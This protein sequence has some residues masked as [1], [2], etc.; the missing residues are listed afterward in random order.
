MAFKRKL[1]RRPAKRPSPVD[2]ICVIN[3][4]SPQQW[5]AGHVAHLA[6]YTLDLLR[7]RPLH[8]IFDM[9]ALIFSIVVGLFCVDAHARNIA[10]LLGGSGD[11]K[12]QPYTLFDHSVVMSIDYFQKKQYELTTLHDGDRQR[13]NEDVSR[14]LK[15]M[16]LKSLTQNNIETAISQIEDMQLGPNDQVVVVIQTHGN[17]QKADEKTHCV[18]IESPQCWSVDRLKTLQKK[19]GGKAKLAIIDMSC[20]SGATLAL[21]D[22]NTCVITASNKHEMALAADVSDFWMNIREHLKHTD[23]DMSLQTLFDTH[24]VRR[25]RYQYGQKMETELTI[26]GFQI[27]TQTNRLLNAF[28]DSSQGLTSLSFDP[29]RIKDPINDLCRSLDTLSKMKDLI[30]L[31]IRALHANALTDF[32]YLDQTVKELNPKIQRL[33]DLINMPIKFQ[34]KDTGMTT[35]DLAELRK[36]GGW[37]KVADTLTKA[38]QEAYSKKLEAPEKLAALSE[39][40]RYLTSVPD[41]DWPPETNPYSDREVQRLTKEIK[42]SPLKTATEKAMRSRNLLLEAGY[43]KARETQSETSA[44]SRFVL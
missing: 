33:N 39:F 23:S 43:K 34:G 6:P 25:H 21:A 20:F 3:A 2:V 13:S 41:S 42:G 18:S 19:L 5:L 4:V 17:P 9:Y 36:M 35:G 16:P 26:S 28:E 11:P 44:C 38:I 10:L 14:A 32:R 7:K 27:S 24:K 29:T 30:E 8:I 22:E 12:G 31:P 15:G 40:S 37:S 1:L